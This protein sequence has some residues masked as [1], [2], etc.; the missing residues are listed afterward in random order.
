[1]RKLP[2]ANDNTVRDFKKF[3]GKNRFF[4]IFF[5]LSQTV[6]GDAKMVPKCFANLKATPKVSGHILGP[7]EKNF[8]NR[9]FDLQKPSFAYVAILSC[10]NGILWGC[11]KTK[12]F[13]QMI[14]MA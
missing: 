1:M 13:F 11:S 14:G 8:P 7:F 2:E 6:S 9:F 3:D 4:S 5:K 12:G 10:E